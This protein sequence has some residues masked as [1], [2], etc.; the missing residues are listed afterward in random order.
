M[1]EGASKTP[2]AGQ[3]RKRR[4]RFMVATIAG[5]AFTAVIVIVALREDPS[6][7][8]QSVPGA[9]QA[10]PIQMGA[11]NEQKKAPRF[12]LS[13]SYDK[14]FMLSFPR[15]TPVFLSFADREAGDGVNVWRD[16]LK[17][18][19]GDKLEFQAVAWLEGLPSLMHGP[20]K[21]IIRDSYDWVLLD[22]SGTASNSYG[23]KPSVPNVFIISADGFVLWE[24]RGAATPE[25]L[26]ALYDFL[27][28]GV[29][30][31]SE[32]TS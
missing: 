2:V 9:L 18:R 5:I 22:F 16:S 30:S 26:Q 27:D 20:V 25:G 23:A 1:N 21:K 14:E 8:D 12:A 31:T 29:L 15:E 7:E 19:Y 4:G 13:D 3:A 11:Q 24:H 6:A 10:E 28:E 17:E 32:S